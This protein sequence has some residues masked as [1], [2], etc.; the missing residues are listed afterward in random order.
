MSIQLQIMRTF[1]NALRI[2]VLFLDYFLEGYVKS[3]QKEQ[4]TLNELTLPVL[5][6]FKRA[7][8]TFFHACG[9]TKSASPDV[10]T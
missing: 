4:Q 1:A 5:G 6:E 2:C 10:S 8:L 3:G 7:K 9:L